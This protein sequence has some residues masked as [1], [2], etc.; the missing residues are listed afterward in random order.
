MP[1]NDPSA[2]NASA[3]AKHSV[4]IIKLSASAQEQIKQ[5][6]EE[7]LQRIL[8]N[9]QNDDQ[10]H[11]H[12]GFV[13]H[14]LHPDL[15]TYILVLIA[16]KKT[17]SQIAADLEVFIGKEQS[18]KFSEWLWN[19]LLELSATN[20]VIPLSKQKM[21]S[22]NVVQSLS[23]SCNTVD[24]HEETIV[25]H[26]PLPE[27]LLFPITTTIPQQP[28][29][30]NNNNVQ[31]MALSLHKQ[32]QRAMDAVSMLKQQQQ[33][34][35]FEN[36]VVVHMSHHDKLW[37]REKFGGA[38]YRREEMMDLSR[39]PRYGV[40]VWSTQ[41][42]KKKM[43]GSQIIIGHGA[44]GA[45]AQFDSQQTN[46]LNMNLL[47]SQPNLQQHNTK[48]SSSAQQYNQERRSD[49]HSGG[50]YKY[51]WQHENR[52]QKRYFPYKK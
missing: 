13:V 27:G 33:H 20:Q 51:Q 22:L 7:E 44:S 23:I 25:D 47:Q 29:V 38:M 16:N 18:I 19:K 2:F 9:N 15:S 3:S 50:R 42:N 37:Q 36:E 31:T 21:S 12:H 26:E 49:R 40:I 5:L 35:P 46:H 8:S 32:Y 17:Q 24:I 1:H 28:P 10:Q 39:K 11:H 41:D 43:N 6:V 30:V 14:T 4:V 48:A 45:S 52:N 34:Q